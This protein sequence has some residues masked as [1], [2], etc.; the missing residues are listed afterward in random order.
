MELTTAQWH[1]R[2]LKQ[3]DWTAPLREFIFNQININS[4][5][6][7]LEVGCGTGAVLSNLPN[8]L[9]SFGIDLQFETLEFATNSC[10]HSDY[11]CGDAFRLPL[12][13]ASFDITFCQYFLL[14]LKSPLYALQEM[15][16]VTK[17]GGFVIAFAEPNHAGRID[18]PAALHELGT[19]QSLSLERQG[20]NLMAGSQLSEL[21]ISAGLMDVVS[22]V[23]AFQKP[24]SGLPAWFDSEWE[25][26]EHDLAGSIDSGML[27]NYKA[28]DKRAW[29]NGSR[30]L[31]VPTFYSFG[32]V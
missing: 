17:Q 9:R 8:G 12:V 30:I 5:G 25:M 13:D 3:A 14:W 23:M 21:F 27:A 24:A 11:V 1:E 26:L 15:K 16:R 22:G 4:A 28:A 31:W 29:K 7:V 18:Y 20:V 19:L 32:K 2:Y 6:S 10:L